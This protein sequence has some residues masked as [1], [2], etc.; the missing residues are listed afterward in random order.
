MFNY[1]FI[2]ESSR[3]PSLIVYVTSCWVG[4]RQSTL[5]LQ[6]E[7]DPMHLVQLIHE[8]AA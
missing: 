5:V 8:Y 6:S 1:C 2:S 3:Q 7:T 4:V